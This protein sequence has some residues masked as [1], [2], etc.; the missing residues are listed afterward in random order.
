MD[1]ITRLGNSVVHHGKNNNRVYLIKLA[2]E[3]FPQ[4]IDELYQLAKI[5]QYTKIIAKVPQWAKRKFQENGYRVEATVAGFYKGQGTAYFLTLYLDKKREIQK[6]AGKAEAIIKY[7]QKISTLM[8]QPDLPAGFRFKLLAPENTPDM[9]E[10]YKKV[11]LSYPFPVF[12]PEYLEQTMKE[13]IV[14]L[15][16]WHRKKLVALSSC[17]MDIEQQNAE[18]TDFATLPEYR[19]KGLASFLLSQMHLSMKHRD[20]LTVYTIARGI[21]YGM[22]ITFAKQ[23]YTFGGRLINNTDIS[24]SIES[25]NVWYLSLKKE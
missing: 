1:C 20:I 7:A 12:S 11:F 22:N 23:G 9:A 10:I 5:N 13:N 21:S 16:I 14:Y 3:D 4:I 25:M 18:M 15:G 24:G 8:A 17:E 2:A 6:D 19:G